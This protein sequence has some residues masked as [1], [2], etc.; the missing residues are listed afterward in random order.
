MIKIFISVRNRL[1]I[2]KKC[3]EALERHSTIPHDIYV[4]DNSTNYKVREHFEYAYNLYKHGLVVQYVFNTDK[5]TFNAFSK[6]VACNHFGKLHMMD[7]QWD[8]CDFI[9][10]MD[11]DIIVTE[12][13]DLYIKQAWKVVKKYGAD[14]HIRIIGQ[15]PGG[16]KS[17]KPFAHTINGISAKVGKLGGS[18]FWN[19][20]PT[21][22]KDVGFLDVKKFVGRNKSHDQQYW[23]IIE[24]INKG[25]PYILGL[26]KK[27]CVHC[28][29]LAGS[30]CNVLTQN[31][32]SKNKLD[33]I[34]F[35]DSE[36]K[37]DNMNFDEFFKSI[38]KNDRL[39]KDW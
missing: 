19:V 14:D 17:R 31:K 28:G 32:T 3:I 34:K 24:R 1:A 9:T 37:I 30:V 25:Q 15:L 16:I 38:K 33:K 21:F 8:R 5:S 36:K 7:P 6:V 2:T 22:F 27:L 11:N 39:M 20:K 35:E 18:S 23:N 29:S 4:F 13:W 12:S 26:E 10:L